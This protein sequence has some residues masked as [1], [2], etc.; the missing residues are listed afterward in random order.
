[1]NYPPGLYVLAN[2]YIETNLSKNYPEI[3]SIRRDG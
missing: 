3:A 2:A 1:M